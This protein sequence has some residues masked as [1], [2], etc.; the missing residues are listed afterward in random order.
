MSDT[1]STPSTHI[2]LTDVRIL[3]GAEL[4]VA[5]AELRAAIRGEI[6]L[7]GDTGY[8]EARAV[9]NAMIDRRPAV[10][11]RCRGAADVRRAVRFA[12]GSGLPLAVRGGGH[13]I[14]GNA[15]CDG[16][17]VMDLSPMR[18]VWVDPASRIARVEAGCT[19]GDVDHETQAHG[20]ALPMGINSTTGIAGLTLGGGFGWLSRSR[21]MTIDSLVSA[22]VVTADGELVR[23]SETENPDLFWAIR[24]G[25]GNFGV[26]TSFE[27]RLHPVGPDVFAGLVVHPLDDAP[28]V[29]RFYREFVRTAPEEL[30]CWFVLRLAPPLPFLPPEWHGREILALAICHSGDLNGAD[31][32]TA[33]LRE[34]GH[35]VGVHV[36]PMPFT[37]WQQILDPL[38]TPGMRNYWKSHDFTGLSDGLID[39]LVDAARHIPDPQTEIAFA[40]LGG[41]MARVPDGATAYG[42]RNAEFAINVHGRWADPAKDEACIGWA[43]GLFDAAAPFATGAVYVN[44]LTQDETDRV[45]AAY[46][47][48]YARLVEVKRRYDPENLFRVNQNIAPG[49]SS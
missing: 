9:W 10:I 29:L 17:V 47:A 42:H 15:V 36:G 25:G 11:V 6:V 16:G 18:S 13:N 20:L 37:A 12:R 26:V 35:P 33:P 7:P 46:G 44:F 49:S 1:V 43:R 27:F 32:A 8:D 45:P 19:L 41:A 34:F 28:A 3:A 23:A 22:D 21:G 48:N 40:L 14:A 4:E 5:I 2:D 31:A 30:V 39:V 24:G 38:L